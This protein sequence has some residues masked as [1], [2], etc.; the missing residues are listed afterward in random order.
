MG[1]IERFKEY[2]RRD[3]KWLALSVG[4]SGLSFILILFG[5]LIDLAIGLQ[6][7]VFSMTFLIVG[8][9]AMIPGIIGVVYYQM[10]VKKVSAVMP[11]E[12][13]TKPSKVPEGEL[14]KITAPTETSANHEPKVTES[15]EPTIEPTVTPEPEK[16]IE[17]EQVAEPEKTIEPAPAVEPEKPAEEPVKEPEPEVPAVE[18]VLKPISPDEILKEPEEIPPMQFKPQAPAPE[19]VEVDDETAKVIN[20]YKEKENEPEKPAEPE[21]APQSKTIEDDELAAIIAKYKKS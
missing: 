12:K 18:V 15:V 1:K 3:N 9:F 8:L 4:C 7:Y 10:T 11:T 21:P 16:V 6:G 20:K 5:L 2:L 13:T 17:Q 19:Y 14:M